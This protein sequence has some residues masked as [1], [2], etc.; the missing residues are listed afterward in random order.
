MIDTCVDELS[1]TIDTKVLK[2]GG[3]SGDRYSIEGYFQVHT[4]DEDYNLLVDLS[5]E[6]DSSL[7]LIIHPKTDAPQN[8]LMEKLLSEA[9]QNYIS[10]DH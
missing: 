10:L 7:K 6:I 2:R 5:Y 8:N 3:G 4:A 9:W 1:Q